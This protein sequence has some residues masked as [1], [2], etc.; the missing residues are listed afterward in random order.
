MIPL[1]EFIS[2]ST[3]DGFSYQDDDKEVKQEVD[4]DKQP[5]RL[6]DFTVPAVSYKQGDHIFYIWFTLSK[7]YT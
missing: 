7:V 6:R 4:Y 1:E 5:A 3:I 2:T